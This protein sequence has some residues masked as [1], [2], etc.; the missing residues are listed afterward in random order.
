V[1]NKNIIAHQEA[2]NINA[3]TKTYKLNTIKEYVNKNYQIL[4]DCMIDKNKNQLEMDIFNNLK[5]EILKN[6]AE[7]TLNQIIF[8]KFIELG[9][10]VNL[11]KYLNASGYRV[12]TDSR[13]MERKYC[14]TD[15]T[16]IV[17]DKTNHNG[18]NP[19]LAQLVEYL[20]RYV[21]RTSWDTRLKKGLKK[22]L[23]T[24]DV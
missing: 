8:K 7:N 13:Y 23:K 10:A 24:K 1:L 22:I 14:T 4:G 11:V 3:Y 5:N 16:A 21:G 9:G 12:K 19:E 20:V 18:I 15:I 17:L 6:S 2:S